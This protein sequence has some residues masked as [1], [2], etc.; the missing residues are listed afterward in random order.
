[1]SG[2]S[3]CPR[4]AVNAYGVAPFSRIQASAQHVSSPPENAMPTRSPTGSASRMTPV[5]PAPGAG[6]AGTSAP[7]PPRRAYAA[8]SCVPVDGV[9]ELLLELGAGHAVARGDEDRV[10]AGD[11]AGDLL[12]RRVVDRVGQRDREAVRRRQHEQLPRRPHAADP[13]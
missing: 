8:S 2:S 11:R 5:I 3:Y 4:S 13:A 12:E 10:L 1:M 6:R 9:A 7:R